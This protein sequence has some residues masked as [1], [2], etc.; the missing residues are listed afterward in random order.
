MANMAE[1]ETTTLIASS[2]VEG[3]SVYNSAGESV[4][5]IDDIM[6]D[7]KS[8][9]AAYAIMSFGGFLGMGADFYPV[10]WSTLKYDTGMDGYV[11]DITKDRLN[12]A[13]SFKEDE[14]PAWGD[15]TYE[16]KVN[17]YYGAP[18]YWD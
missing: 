13:P 1:R 2:K 5:S 18:N 16:T 12:G 14:E 8:G 10:P 17:K 6:I 7:K 9:K 11:T 4:G 3:A 15:R